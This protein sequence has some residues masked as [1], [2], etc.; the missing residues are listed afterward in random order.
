MADF[1][2]YF[3]IFLILL[4][5]LIFMVAFFKS[6]RAKS[7]LPPTPFPLPIIGHLHLLAPS[8]HQAFHKL[9]VQHGPVFRFFLGS[10]PCVVAGSTE[11]AKELFKT[12]NDAF[13]DRPHNST[14]DYFTYGGRGFFFAP[15][16][17]YWKFMKKIVISEL[18]NGKT[19]ES[20]LPIR[21][22]EVIRLL[23]VLSQSAKVGKSVEL[24]GELIK[25]TNNVISRMLMS[26]RCSEED[27]KAEDIRE[28]IT[29][30]GELIGKFNLSD[31][32]WFCKYLDLQRIG[33]RSLNIRRRFDALIENIMREHEEARKQDTGEM[34]DLLNILLHISEDETMDKKLTRENI[35]AFILDVFGAGTDTSALTTEWALSELINHPNIMKKAV[36]EIDHVVGK[37]RLLQESDIPN[38]PYLQAI[39]KETLRLHPTVPMI[40]R[41]STR[42]CI[43]GGYD[44]PAK[45]TIFFNVWGHGRDPTN[46]ENPLEFRPERF[47]GRKLDVRGQDFQLLPFGSG[48]RMCPGISLGLHVVHATLGS[49]IQC[50]EWKAGKEGNLTS[51]DMEEGIGITLPR[52]NSLVC[53]P[54][55]RLH[56]I[57]LSM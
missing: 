29:E 22:D 50:F 45:T 14:L 1:H 32:I 42:D 15:Y 24:E 34:N 55:V 28:I 26:K 56:L 52:A 18:L 39:V 11:T 38:L 2:G 41:I 13:L 25:M 19:L 7:H 57:P 23:Q 27:D 46:W 54:V 8:P 21:R 44:I 10:T 20:L 53:V 37:N 49:M 43:V 16:G 6:A 12:Y 4:V 47:E 51:V 40:Q 9:S 31:H 33:K 30:I 36:E 5:S 35:K 17:A 3:N 48:S